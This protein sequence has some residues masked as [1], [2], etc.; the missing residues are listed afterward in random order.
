MVSTLQHDTMQ[1]GVACL[2]MVCR[3]YGRDY[4]L[5]Y[6]EQICHATTEGVSLLGISEAATR[7]G[8]HTVCGKVE[9]EALANAPLPA[10]LHW[11]Q[12][13]FVVLYKAMRSKYFVADPGKGLVKY[14][15]K[16]FGTNWLSTQSEGRECGIAMFIEPTPE[17]Y[18]H[19]SERYGQLRSF[20][21]LF[22]YL[23]QYRRYFGQIM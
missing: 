12:N 16:E 13:H 23:K 7:L 1:Y 20:S 5:G 17:F 21:F 18:K 6:L 19:K 4:S 14:S 8:L 2:Q 9:L 3:H 10:I 11:R 22:G 15:D